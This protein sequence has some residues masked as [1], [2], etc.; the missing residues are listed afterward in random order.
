MNSYDRIY[1][2]ILED[3]LVSEQRKKTR[4][5]AGLMA[6]AGLLG[7]LTGGLKGTEK[8]ETP[9]HVKPSTT[10]SV[11]SKRASPKLPAIANLNTRTTASTSEREPAEPPTTPTHPPWKPR[12][13]SQHSDSIKAMNRRAAASDLKLDIRRK[14]REIDRQQLKIDYQNRQKIP[15][16]PPNPNRISKEESLK[17][18]REKQ[19][20]KN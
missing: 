14:Q 5:R 6:T 15:I 17:R 13:S 9:T 7:V 4:G 19:Q 12:S 18:W 10:Q 11:A 2:I 16:A 20:G 8:T 1:N 3:L